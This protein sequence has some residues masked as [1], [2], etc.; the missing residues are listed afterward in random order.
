MEAA[1]GLY[2]HRGGDAGGFILRKGRQVTGDEFA[3]QVRP[4]D[5]V[6]VWDANIQPVALFS[7]LTTQWNHTQG[8]KT[9]LNYTVVFSMLDRET[10]DQEEWSA[11]FDD[12]QT[13]EMAALEQMAADRPKNP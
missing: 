12:L 8:F 10:T 6:E 3:P 13:M 4:A 5:V 7:R 11:L 9:G 1:K 2:K